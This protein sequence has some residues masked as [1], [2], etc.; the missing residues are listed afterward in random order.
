L[1]DSALISENNEI[2]KG[3]LDYD[4]NDN[5]D[6]DD[7][8]N[9]DDNNNNNNNNNNDDNNHNDN[10]DNNNKKKKKNRNIDI[11]DRNDDSNNNSKNDENENN[12]LLPVSEGEIHLCKI[13]TLEDIFIENKYISIDLLKVRMCIYKC[14]CIGIYTHISYSYLYGCVCEYVY[15]CTGLL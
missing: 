14:I 2:L 11:I 5:N 3:L 12:N 6:I 1:F 8:N 4:N 13:R 9:D 10:N 15:K 7:N